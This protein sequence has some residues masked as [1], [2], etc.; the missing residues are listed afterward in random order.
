M[1]DKPQAK[2][3]RNQDLI[4][5]TLRDIENPWQ[6]LAQ[7]KRNQ[8]ITML[9]QKVRS[10]FLGIV[11]AGLI[12]TVTEPRPFNMVGEMLI[13]FGGLLGASTTISLLRQERTSNR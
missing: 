10:V 5:H 12:I 13:F 9:S 6:R 1:S 7:A 2:D 11:V 8:R 3:L 4:M